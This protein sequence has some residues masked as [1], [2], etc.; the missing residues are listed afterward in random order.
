MIPDID[1]RI[2]FDLVLAVAAVIC[3]R[4]RGEI[5]IVAYNASVP[6][7]CKLPAWSVSNVAMGASRLN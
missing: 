3:D 6:G 7:G 5:D 1:G 2:G 4:P